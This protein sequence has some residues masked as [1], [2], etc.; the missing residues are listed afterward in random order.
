[1]R[2]LMRILA[3]VASIAG[4]LASA[5]TVLGWLSVTPEMVGQAAYDVMRGPAPLVVMFVGGSLFGWGVTKLWSD[6]RMK[7]ASDAHAAEIES[8]KETKQRHAALFDEFRTLTHNEQLDIVSV[9]LS[10]P[11]GLAPSDEQRAHMGD[12]VKMKDFLRHDPV[13]DR[14]HLVDGVGEMLLENPRHVYDLMAARV[15]DLETA[16]SEADENTTGAV[17]EQ[18]RTPSDSR[19]VYSNRDDPFAALVP[20]EVPFLLRVYDNAQ[21]HVGT[22][23]LL[24]ARSLRGKGAIYRFDAPSSDFIEESNAALTKEWIPIMNERADEL[25]K[26]VEG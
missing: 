14:M 10:E 1:M 15:A 8:L 25:R 11:G 24:V 13:S 16:M 6:H 22:E 21:A 3:A 9:W 19:M 4:F 2:R 20:A 7:R 17:A 12:W 23:N 18:V 5:A 26:M